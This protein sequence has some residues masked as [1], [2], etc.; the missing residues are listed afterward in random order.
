MCHADSNLTTP[1]R[2]GWAPCACTL[3]NLLCGL[4]AV[5]IVAWPDPSAWAALPLPEWLRDPL[6]AA[7]IVLL[8]GNVLDVLDGGLARLTK[9]ASEFGARLD[10]LADVAT[11]GIAPAVLIVMAHQAAPTAGN[12]A[13]AA[14]AAP[15]GSAGFAIIAAALYAMA[16]TWRLARHE[17]ER[18]SDSAKKTNQSPPP[19]KG[20]RNFA[21]LPSPGATAV[22]SAL[23]LY[24][25]RDPS[26]AV[27]NTIRTYLPAAAI[28]LG[29]LMIS[30]LPYPHSYR[31]FL[32]GGRLAGAAIPGVL[33][34]AVAVI[35]LPGVLLAI[36]TWYLSS[37]PAIYLSRR[38]LRG[39]SA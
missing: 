25:Q 27:A 14:A 33:I 36:L 39:S 5:L 2:P 21:G 29:L 23:V 4:A 6:A 12:T 31:A 38:E 32:V 20:P 34:A 17:V 19:R 3:A 7:A 8:L 13:D 10:S 35:H 26:A 22:L 18:P 16:V 28:V 24:M 11:C 1:Q 37:G 15:P 30:R 9:S